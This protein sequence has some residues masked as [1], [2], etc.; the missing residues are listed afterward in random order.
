[1]TIVS[2]SIQ[3]NVVDYALPAIPAALE[4]DKP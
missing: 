3:A 4:S 2:V 1:M